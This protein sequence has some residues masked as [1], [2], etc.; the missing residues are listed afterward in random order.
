MDLGAEQLK[1]LAVTPEAHVQTLFWTCGKGCLQLTHL[2]MRNRLGNQRC[3]DVM[4]AISL[5]CV[6]STET[7]VL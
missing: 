4:L 6:L 2:L 3:P 7:G 5:P 1:N